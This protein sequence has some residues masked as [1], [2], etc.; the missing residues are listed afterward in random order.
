MSSG[1]AD[2]L[3]A[4]I[5]R[6]LPLIVGLV[7]L[8]VVAVNVFEHLQG[9][10][11][12][13][14]ASVDI[15]P[16]T[17]AE[18]VTGTTPPILDPTEVLATA[19]QL[20]GAAEVYQLAAQRTSNRYGNAGTLSSNTAV[21]QIGT[22]E[23]LQFT[24]TGKSPK[25]AV[26]I[27]NAGANAFVIYRAQVTGA[28]TAAVITE[29]QAKTGTLP[30]GAERAQ[31]VSEIQKLQLLQS[32]AGSGATVVQTATSA[33]KTSPKLTKDSAIGFSIGL[34]IA[35]LLVALRE[36]VDTRVR[37]EG[38]V[39]EVLGAPVLAS[40][41][42]HPRRT[43]IVTVGR[44]ETMFTDAYA[45]LA[46]QLAPDRRETEHTVLAVTSALA[47]E[48]KTTTV[49]N[50]AIALAKRG[51]QVLLADFDFHKPT[52]ANLF[53]IPAGVGGALQ[54]LDGTETLD[55]T[56][57]QISLDGPKAVATL[58]A[59]VQPI[60]RRE[61]AAPGGRSGVRFDPI[62]DERD[63]GN[64]TADASA[65]AGSLVVLPSGKVGATDA[66]ARTA[67]LGPLLR[68]LSSRAPI[69]ILDTPPALLTVEMTELAQLVDMVLVVVRHG[70]VSQRILRSLGRHART[71]PAELTGA[72]MTGVPV[73][74]TGYTSY[75]T[76]R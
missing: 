31:I 18:I 26:G 58:R 46:A 39:E 9:A 32:A 40:I 51:E 53:A 22:T 70:Q 8:G 71:W 15:S 21:S 56:L 42:T 37:S 12:Q 5:R 10:K 19:Q 62:D 34:V 47:G 60:R 11:Y 74:T 20:A 54:I 24:A 30:A 61:R 76:G 43:P 72:V 50:L 13:A 63:G 44:Y 38:S 49:A 48:G 65:R 25:Q 41:R 7:I 59:E 73:S 2:A 75:Y 29:L 23:L 36:A 68:E 67:Q 14:S 28:Q 35:L 55:Q 4:A 27:A 1:G 45:L 69:V 64:G 3:K 57:W 33:D 17:E 16:I 66:H 6:S 52:L